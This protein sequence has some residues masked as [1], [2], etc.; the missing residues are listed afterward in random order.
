MKANSILVT[1]LPKILDNCYVISLDF[2]IAVHVYIT[3]ATVTWK[4]RG[5]AAS[6][7][8]RGGK[9]I[10]S[11]HPQDGNVSMKFIFTGEYGHRSIRCDEVR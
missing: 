11:I 7:F 9:Q 4:K 10:L 1:G 5:M 6:G 8:G 3:Q 2:V